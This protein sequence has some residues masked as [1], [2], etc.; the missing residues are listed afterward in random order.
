MFLYI[1]LFIAVL[2]N[3]FAQLSIKMVS[4]S[5]GPIKQFSFFTFFRTLSNAYFWLSI[6]LYFCALFLSIEIYKKLPLSI[7]TPVFMGMVFIVVM[8]L[9]HIFFGDEISG[10]TIF[11]II[12]ILCGVTVTFIG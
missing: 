4:R 12:L 7:V 6:A 3:A 2:C 1:L 10:K 8:I 9:S 5:L 11:G